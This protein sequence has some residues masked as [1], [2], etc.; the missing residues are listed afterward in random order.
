MYFKSNGEDVIS[1]K[2]R[3]K[4]IEAVKAVAIIAVVI[5]HSFGT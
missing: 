3:S 4:W 5:D 2:K 1:E